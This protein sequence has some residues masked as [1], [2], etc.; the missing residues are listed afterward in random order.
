MKASILLIFVCSLLVLSGCQILEKASNPITGS[1]VADAS[2]QG[3]C[4]QQK[5]SYFPEDNN[6]RVEPIPTEDMML[7]CK[8]KYAYYEGGNFVEGWMGLENFTDWYNEH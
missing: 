6:V 7:G 3:T 8:C 4:E 1:F 5:L 2:C